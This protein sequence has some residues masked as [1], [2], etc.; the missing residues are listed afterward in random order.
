MRSDARV[1]SGGSIYRGARFWLA[2]TFCLSCCAACFL[3]WDNLLDTPQIPAD[4]GG[5]VVTA[6]VLRSGSADQ[7]YV[8]EPGTPQYA[9]ALARARAE[10]GLVDSDV[11]TPYLYPPLFAKALAWLPWQSWKGLW[12]AWVAVMTTS[13]WAGFFVS[14]LLVET[15]PI[16]AAAALAALAS[17]F[18]ESAAQCIWL[19]Q[20]TP[21]MFLLVAGALLAY[22]TRRPSLAGALLGVAVFLKITPIVLLLVWIVHRS[23][24]AL[25]GFVAGVAVPAALSLLSMGFS[26]HVT[27]AKKVGEA[28]GWSLAS[29]NSHSISSFV[30]RLYAAPDDILNWRPQ[31]LPTTAKVFVSCVT[32]VLLIAFG[33]TVYRSVRSRSTRL[34]SAAALLLTLSIPTFSWT[35]YAVSLVPVFALVLPRLRRAVSVAPLAVATLG[36]AL[37][38]AKP[39]LPGS[40]P[41]LYDRLMIDGY[42]AIYVFGILGI[43]LLASRQFDDDSVR[44]VTAP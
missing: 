16:E 33:W 37:F 3:R 17:I 38:L 24:K 22:Q 35:H 8:I 27:Y 34:A 6:Q 5:Y 1:G 9:A 15:I 28:L 44:Q 19:G 23:R 18:L 41:S 21:I 25:A 20:V 42:T 32:V 36:L 12:R 29:F 31:H 11:I 40:P 30:A 39:L 43:A 7:I 10:L 14:F 4:F 26:L 2:L 13:L